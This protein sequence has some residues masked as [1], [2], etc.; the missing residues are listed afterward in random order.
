M[1]DKGQ[2]AYV[3]GAVATHLK[4]EAKRMTLQQ[5]LEGAAAVGDEDTGLRARVL[6]AVAALAK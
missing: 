4:G 3:L 6:G 5:A 2:R 1:K